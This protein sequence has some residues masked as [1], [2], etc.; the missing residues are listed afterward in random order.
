MEKNR[1]ICNCKTCGKAIYK[2]DYVGYPFCFDCRRTY[3]K[4]NFK[5]ERKH[6][7]N[8]MGQVVHFHKNQAINTLAFDDWGVAMCGTKRGGHRK[9]T[10]FNDSWVSDD[11]VIC[12]RCIKAF[13][14]QIKEVA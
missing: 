2:S 12:I 7:G 3:A 5:Q 8:K 1:F 4:N 10:I 14:K 6:R 11:A 9:T 13:A